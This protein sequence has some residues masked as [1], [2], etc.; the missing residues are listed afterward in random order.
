MA[1]KNDADKEDK[2][3]AAA[4][5]KAAAEAAAAEKAA[6]DPKLVK[7]L[8]KSIAQGPGVNLEANKKYDLEPA[9]AAALI[10]G[11]YA[12]AVK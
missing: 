10:K 4:A 2:D 3:A 6:K 7:V 5:E 9:F 12:E 1:K 8:M 11:G